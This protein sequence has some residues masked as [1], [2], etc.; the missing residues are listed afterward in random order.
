MSLKTIKIL[1]DRAEKMGYAKRYEAA[2]LAIEELNTMTTIEAEG[3]ELANRARAM[4]KKN[5]TRLTK[6]NEDKYE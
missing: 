6:Q 1:L 4:L 5:W 2:Q 3:I